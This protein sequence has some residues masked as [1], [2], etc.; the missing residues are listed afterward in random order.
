MRAEYKWSRAFLE[1]FLFHYKVSRV[2]NNNETAKSFQK[3]TTL[4]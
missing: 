2:I 1:V 4:R 3:F